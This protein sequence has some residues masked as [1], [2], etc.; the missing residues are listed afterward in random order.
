MLGAMMG[1]AISGE[2]NK[3]VNEIF[4]VDDNDE[5]RELLSTILSL[6]GFQVTGF[7]EGASFLREAGVRT[8]VCV[9]LDIVMP[10][11]SG[12][13]VLK[14]LAARNYAAPVFLISARRDSPVVVEAMRNGAK[15][16]IEKPFDPYTAV[17]RVREAVELWG[18]RAANRGADLHALALDAGVRLSYMEREVLAHIV[19]GA[20][21]GEIAERL[22]LNK[23]SAA[24]HRWRII[25]KLGAK[26]PAD[27]VRRML[28]KPRA[29][30]MLE[31]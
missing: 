23:K 30:A 17:L 19:A 25:K 15:D 10:G 13:E 28:T 11:L 29:Q 4:V 8:P 1:A 18:R 12:L 5:Y 27:L 16:F 26:N 7:S 20:S 2:E 21:N 22:G 14:K 31:R 3:P 9:F 6:E 24:N